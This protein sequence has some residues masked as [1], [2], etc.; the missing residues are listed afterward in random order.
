MAD[1]KP[2][3]KQTNKRLVIYSFYLVHLGIILHVLIIPLYIT[4]YHNLSFRGKS[5]TTLS[6]NLSDAKAHSSVL[7]HCIALTDMIF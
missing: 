3:P 7:F 1:Q 6:I 4:P 2:K 5:F